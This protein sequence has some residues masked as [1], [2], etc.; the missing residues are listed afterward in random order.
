MNPRTRECLEQAWVERSVELGDDEVGSRAYVKWLLN[1]KVLSD[2]F[3]ERITWRALELATETPTAGTTAS[4]Y[5]YDGSEGI[6]FDMTKPIAG[7]EGQCAAFGQLYEEADPDEFVPELQARIAKLEAQSI[8]WRTV[9]DDG[10]PE[11]E[12]EGDQYL[13]QLGDTEFH[14]LDGEPIQLLRWTDNTGIAA[15]R[16]WGYV[17][18]YIPVSELKK[19]PKGPGAPEDAL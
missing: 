3:P 4:R 7:E 12:D 5:G 18:R 19:L 1:Q 6:W 16:D 9:E 14:R 13:C 10:W 15:A 11:V 17:K 2:D 8:S